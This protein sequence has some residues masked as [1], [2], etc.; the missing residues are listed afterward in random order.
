MDP[1]ALILEM[2]EYVLLED[3]ERALRVL[4]DLKDLGIRL[5]LDDF[6]TGY[7]SLGSLRQLPFD[8]VK[9]DRS[10]VAGLGLRHEDRAIVEASEAPS[11]SANAA[12][13]SATTVS[14]PAVAAV[15]RRRETASAQRVHARLALSSVRLCG[16]SS[17]GPSVDSTIGSSVIATAVETSGISIPP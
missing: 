13:A 7:S 16:Q 9:V 14:S 3:N 6:G 5:A 8:Q 15:Q 17:R 12:L 4:T 10:F 1:G 11:W 2:T